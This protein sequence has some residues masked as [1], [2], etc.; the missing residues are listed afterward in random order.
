MKSLRSITTVDTLS[1]NDLLTRF[2][3]PEMPVKFEHLTDD[4]PAREK[5]S[6]DYFKDVAGD[7][8]VPLYDSQPSKD[9]KHQHAPAAQMPLTD[10]LDK[11]QAG[12]N[13]LRLFFYNILQEV[14]E[15]T[16]DFDYP[17][18]GLPFFRKLPVLFMGGTGAKVQMHYDI[19][20]ADIFLCHF[21]G[22]KKVM[23]FPPDQTPLMYKVPFSFSSLFDVNYRT[24]DLEKYPALQYLE[25]YET[26]LNHGD[27]LYIP[28]GWWHYIE[29]EELSFSMA[30]RAFPR[31]PKNLAT[32]LKNLLWTRS[33]EGLM[34]KTVGQAWNDRNEKRAV[35]NTHR[36]LA[37]HHT[38][39]KG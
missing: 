10:Y 25:G 20:L 18:I 35:Q 4:W 27:I 19:D 38:S 9:R 15:L 11:L 2:K 26:E 17:D 13:D 34:R 28:P 8:V 16:R 7:R 6:I 3:R 24:P 37:K 14:P 36:Y 31:R 1:K 39:P 12:E 30:L 32:M 23:L 33:I 29:Y 5:W 22:K 21:G